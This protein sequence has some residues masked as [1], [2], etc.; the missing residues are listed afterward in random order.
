VLK[1]YKDGVLITTNDAPSG[2]PVAETG[3]LKLGRH[4][5]AAPAQYFTG[6]VDEATIYNRVLSVGEIRYL[7]GF[8]PMVDPGT[9]ALAA[10]YPLDND[11][12]D[13]SGNGN[14]GTIFG[15]PT[16]VEG[17]AGM[18]LKF[19]GA[20]DYVDCGNNPILAITDAVTV[21]ARIKVAAQGLDHKVGGNQD[22]AN[23]GYKMTVFNNNRVEFE[24][25]TASN[26]AVLNRNVVGGTEIKVDIWYHVAGVYSLE[27]GYIRTYVNGE[28]DRELLTTQALGASPGSFKIGCE[29]FTTGSYNFNGVMDDIRIYNRALSEAEVRY[30]A[31]N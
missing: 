16:F 6:T 9:D 12:L 31:N 17:V 18:A 15:D 3:T 29:P 1:A 19:D 10:Y 30:L 5:T 7:A 13:G 25:R 11:V 8:R 27:D 22:N 26:S 21:S 4:A 2:P 20:G 14:N 23:G 24:I 28:M